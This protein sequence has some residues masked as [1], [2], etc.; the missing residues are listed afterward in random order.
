MNSISACNIEE[1]KLAKISK[2]KSKFFLKLVVIKYVNKVI[3][4]I[5]SG[6]T[7]LLPSET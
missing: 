5:I 6:L 7:K 2:S 1:I 4:N 3:T